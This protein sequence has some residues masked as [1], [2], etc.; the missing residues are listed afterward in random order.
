MNKHT[1]QIVNSKAIQIVEKINNNKNTFL[2][3]GLSTCKYCKN[4]L[5]FAE[6]N[7]LQ[8]KY[9]EMDK[10]YEIFIPILEKITELYPSFDIDSTHQTFPVIFYNKKFIGGC[11]ELKKYNL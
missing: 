4:A 2:I 9:Y 6:K 5:E 10:Y 3:F 7:S 1:Q 11:S 8:F